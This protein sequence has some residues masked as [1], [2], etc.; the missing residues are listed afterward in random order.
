MRFQT[1]LSRTSRCF[2]WCC[3]CAVPHASSRGVH[4]DDDDDDDAFTIEPAAMA[5]LAFPL[6][7]W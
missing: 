5:A 2:T 4:D 6:L 1:T 7:S 3:A